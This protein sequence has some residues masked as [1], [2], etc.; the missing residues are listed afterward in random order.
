ME[1]FAVRFPKRGLG[2]ARRYCHLL[3]FIVN[4]GQLLY[5]YAAVPVWHNV[6]SDEKRAFLELGVDCDN[7]GFYHN[8]FQNFI[9]CCFP[10]ITRQKRYI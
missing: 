6:V 4:R 7:Y 10:I 3:C 5:C 2:D 1:R 9:W 8:Y